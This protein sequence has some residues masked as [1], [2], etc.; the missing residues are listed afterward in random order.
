MSSNTAGAFYQETIRHKGVPIH[1]D[2][3]WA[4]DKAFI[5]S[6]RL[7]RTAALKNDWQEDIDNP[8]STI[9]HLKNLGGKVDLLRFW[10]RIPDSEPKY[11]YYYE[12]RDVA[13]IPVSDYKH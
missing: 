6:G 11:R 12:W 8:E 2:A 9:H 3:V 7:I 13:A 10:Q 1:L 5:I 4:E